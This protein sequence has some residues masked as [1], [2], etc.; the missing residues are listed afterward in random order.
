M[1]LGAIGSSIRAVLKPRFRGISCISFRS[2]KDTGHSGRLLPRCG[3][4]WAARLARLRLAAAFLAVAAAGG[5]RFLWLGPRGGPAEPGT[6]IGPSR[7]QCAPSC[8]R[9]A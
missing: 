4:A 5:A 8:L 1:N 9:T 6:G 7:Y 3:P 2:R